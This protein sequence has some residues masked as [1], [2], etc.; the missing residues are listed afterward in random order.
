MG[1]RA[2]QAADA[3]QQLIRN[4]GLRK[5]EAIPSQRQLSER[6]EI[7]RTALREGISALVARGELRSEPGR[8]VF[9]VRDYREPKP[10]AV[11]WPTADISPS[12]VY[13]LR[14]VIEPFVAGLVATRITPPLISRLEDNVSA[15]RASLREGAMEAA[16]EL[17]FQ[18]HSLILETA[19]NPTLKEAAM[20]RMP[21]YRTSQSLP[22]AKQQ[23][24]MDTWR[25]HRRIVLALKRHSSRSAARAMRDH[26]LRAA[27]RGGNKFS[28][29]S[30]D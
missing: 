30:H 6:L 10:A 18:F 19:G 7:S 13:Q 21:S 2:D 15:T 27:L 28:I 12:D 17:D 14:Y 29:A 25:E 20:T 3:V 22:F 11:D 16:A 26:I 4:E 23:D 24:R 1:I 8:G 9:V 5:G